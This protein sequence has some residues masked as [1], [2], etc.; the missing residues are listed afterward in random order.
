MSQKKNLDPVSLFSI[1]EFFASGFCELLGEPPI[2]RYSRAYRRWLENCAL[3]EYTGEL[4]YPSG[5]WLEETSAVLIPNYSFTFAWNENAYSKK[6][7]DVQIEQLETLKKL[8]SL[9]Q[10]E[11]DLIDKI[12][13]VHTIGGRGYTHSIV[14]YGRV[15]T[16]GLDAYSQRILEMVTINQNNSDKSFYQAMLDL[17]EGIRVWHNRLLGKLIQSSSNYENRR[18]LIESFQ[19][20]PFK[21]ARN[22]L[23]AIVAYNIIYYLDG[24]DNPGR[25]DQVLQPYYTHDLHIDHDQ[26]LELMSAFFDNVCS[27]RGW[28]L[29][30]GGSHADGS[31]AYLEMT[32]ICLQAA[33]SRYRPSI[34]LKVRPDMPE[35]IWDLA[36]ESLNTGCGQPAFYNEPGYLKAL[37]SLLP[38]ILVE[39]LVQWNGGGCTE[40]MLH[41][42]S[43][44]GSL[45]A[46]INL[47][48]IL[49]T[50]LEKYLS[51][52][53]VNFDDILLAFKDNI[54]E[55]IHGVLE[56]LNAYF[57]ARAEHRPQPVRSLLVDDCIE[58]GLEFNAGGARYNWSVVNVA[59]LANVADSLQALREVVFVNREITASELLTCLHQDFL[60]CET[61]RQR[62][63]SCEKFGNDKETVDLLASEI[64]Q[65]IYEEILS[66]PCQRGG[67]FLP[68]HI[69]FETFGY[70]GKQVGASPDGRRAFEPLSDSI[71]PVQGRDCRGPTAMLNSVSRL[72][73]H[74]AAGTPVLNLRLSKSGMKNSASRHNLRA[75]IETYFRMGGMQ[76]QVS[77]L[78][79]LELLD[80]LDHP[81][82]HED[83]IVRIG[84]YSTYFNWLPDDL[85]HEV[86]KRTEYLM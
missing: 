10:S 71:G 3:G 67:R 32:E 84:G 42:C 74:L 28:S 76:L 77:V 16:E 72:P 34:E 60:G 55:T 65:F 21:P 86:I 70:S 29:A 11:E 43:N 37:S 83:L 57:V 7:N 31:P 46:G 2:I 62:L 64:A 17:I 63:L 40:T 69:M 73:Q 20:V 23:E 79:Q 27:N 44:V 24:C 78:D 25:M 80:A 38:E 48:L 75:L 61:I 45:D 13:T 26:A 47:L 35:R 4:L 52:D 15:L 51:V 1:G 6:L 54:K 85:K 22:F 9:Y 5:K 49:E 18:L 68:A 66:H 59:G 41:G 58:E 33:R 81:E 36:M 82:R 8:Q 12:N 56:Q 39:D 30:I 14:N 50:I 53:T 19:Q